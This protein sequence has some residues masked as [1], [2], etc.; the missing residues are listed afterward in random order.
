MLNK[1]LLQVLPVDNKHQQPTKVNLL[2]L[3]NKVLN[4]LTINRNLNLNSHTILNS[5]MQFN[6]QTSLKLHLNSSS[7]LMLN[8]NLNS[9]TTNSL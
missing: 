1:Q 2:G 8:S 4:H 5:N 3:L 9:L 6:I 7:Q